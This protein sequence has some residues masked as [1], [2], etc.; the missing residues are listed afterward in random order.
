MK[1]SEAIA[2]LQQIQE[3]YGDISITGGYMSDDRPLSEIVVTD[4]EGME[5]WPNGASGENEVGGVFLS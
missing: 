3:K 2:T 4:T 5:V 1:I